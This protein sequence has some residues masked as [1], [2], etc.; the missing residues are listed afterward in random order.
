MSIPSRLL[1]AAATLVA[2]SSAHAAIAT[3]GSAQNV[4]A[5]TDISTLGTL[6][7]A[8]NLG[9][10][11]SYA[12][13]GVTFTG[14]TAVPSGWVGVVGSGMQSVAPLPGI[15]TNYASALNSC[16]YAGTVGSPKDFTSFTGLTVGATYQFQV[17]FADT[18]N[19]TLGTM[20]WDTGAST[21]SI[22]L[23]SN[24]GASPFAQYALAE[25]TA[26]STSQTFR[27]TGLAEGGPI[28]SM[29]QLRAVP[30]PS[31]YGLIGAGVLASA[32]AV[33][34]RKLAGKIA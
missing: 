21:P 12:I 15:G 10:A 18:R 25:F 22:T 3:W 32:A 16:I 27:I 7:Q 17:W 20:Q 30:E 9:N 14:S 28:M 23:S 24:G 2:A 13:N 6:V 19:T 4:S 34:R 29:Y 31:T 5:D 1:L 33:R 11:A 8:Y 26:D